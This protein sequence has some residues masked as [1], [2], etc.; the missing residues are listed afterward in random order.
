MQIVI[1][2]GNFT[3]SVNL[4]NNPQG[5]R[6][7]VTTQYM[8]NYAIWDWEADGCQ[9]EPPQ[10]WKYKG[11]NEHFIATLSLAEVATLGPQGLEALVNQAA[12]TIEHSDN[13]T[14]EYVIGWDLLDPGQETWYERCDR[15]DREE[16]EAWARELAAEA[17]AAQAWGAQGEDGLFETL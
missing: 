12:P 7:L 13:Y 10:G 11:A 3:N 1:G 6:L 16:R 9:G 5:F 15:E 2:Q 17:A 14:R 4:I 8:E